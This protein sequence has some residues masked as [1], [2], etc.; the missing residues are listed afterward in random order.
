MI[1]GLLTRVGGGD[2][3]ALAASM[4]IA[5]HLVDMSPLSTTGAVTIAGVPDTQDVKPL[6]NKL[7]AWGLSMTVVGAIGCWI[8]FR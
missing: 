6:Y 7:L 1:P 5:G 8:F 2:P 3:L 4:N